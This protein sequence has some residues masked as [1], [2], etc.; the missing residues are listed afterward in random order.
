MRQAAPAVEKAGDGVR[1]ERAASRGSR[2]DIG[3]GR[4]LFG[5]DIEQVL[6]E[7][8]DG[9]GIPE[10]LMRIQIGRTVIA[11]A[12]VEMP[13]VHQD[14]EA[15]EFVEGARPDVVRSRHAVPQAKLAAPAMA[16]FV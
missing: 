3:G 5:H 1:E 8:P 7:P 16:G 4:D 10:Q 13:I 12:V 11:V 14:F 6:S 15:S 9:G 2:D